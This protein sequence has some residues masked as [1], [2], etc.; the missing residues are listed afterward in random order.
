QSEKE[1]IGG[2]PGNPAGE[3]QQQQ[4]PP[5]QQAAT[6]QPVPEAAK[7]APPPQTA[8]ATVMV[9]T[10]DIVRVTPDGRAVIAGRAAAKSKIV[11]LDGGKETPHTTTADDRGEWVLTVENP[12]FTPGQHELRVV[13]HIEGRAPVTSEQAVV[14]VVPEPTEKEK[15]TLVMID[16]PRG[17]PTLVQP[18]TRAGVP[19]SGDLAL[20]TVTYDERGVVTVTGEA[21]AGSPVRIYIDN[22]PQGEATADQAKRWR[23]AATDPVTVGKHVLRVERL[24]KDGKVEQR[25]EESFERIVST[26]AG[27]KLSIV[28]GDN[29][30]NIARA[31]YGEGWRYTVIFE[32]NKDQ[33]KDPNLI[34]PGQVFSVPKS[35]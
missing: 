33:I 8:A 35:N 18:P 1:A 29:L 32:A 6:P 11:L 21:T 26:A 28:V 5:Q 31:H 16:P 12:P 9:P 34:Y 13:Q 30:W 27:G 4:P 23:I 19:R 17:A 7:P 22:K 15:Q 25:L 3:Q 10:F 14:I 20:S 24:G 2:Q